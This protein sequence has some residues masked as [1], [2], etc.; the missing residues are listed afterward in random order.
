MTFRAP[1]CSYRAILMASAFAALPL[2]AAMADEAD[3]DSRDILVIGS[4]ESGTIAALEQQRAADNSINVVSSDDV[5]RFPDPNIAEALQRVPGI[6]VQRDQGEGRYIN[7]RGGPAD[8]S[9]VSVD[10]VTLTAPDPST[11]AI[12]LDTIPSG[13]DQHTG[14]VEDVAALAGRRFDHRHRQH[15]H[16]LRIRQERHQPER[17]VGHEPQ[18][19]RRQRRARFGVRQQ[20]LCRRP[21]GR[22]VQRQLFAHG[23]RV[24]NIESVWDVLDTPEGGEVLGLVES[25]FKDYDTRRE[26]IAFTGALEFEPSDTAKYYVR[27]SYS[28]FED[29]EYRNQLLVIWEDG[30][31]Q[32]GATDASAT[33]SDIRIAKQFRHRVQRNEIMTLTAGGENDLGGAKLDYNVAWTT[34]DQTYPSRNELLYRSSLRPTASYDFS[35]NPDQPAI[36]LFNSGEH[37]NLAAY[38]FRENTYRANTTE[39]EEFSAAF[40]VSFPVDDDFEVKVGARYR[41]RTVTADEERWRDRRASSA[42]A[43]TMAD[44]LSDRP[45]SNYDYDLGFK[46]DPSLAKG[47]LLDLRD[48]GLTQRRIPQSITADYAADEK[49]LAGYVMTRATFGATDVILGLR[50]EKTRFDGSSPTFNE[51]TEVIGEETM[52]KR[53]TNWFPN[54]TVRHN[55]TDNLV[56]RAAVTRGI[57]RPN[58]LDLVPRTV[59]NTEGATIRVT[60]G[61]PLLEPTISTNFDASL[62]YYIDRSGVVSAGFFYKDIKDFRFEA[63]RTGTYLGLPAEITQPENAPDGY[64]YGIEVNLSQKLRFLPG[65]LSNFG[66]FANY[67]YTSSR[68]NLAAPYA[69]RDRYPLPGQ[70]KHVWNASVYYE[71]SDF[72]ARLAYTKRSAFLSEL[73]ADDGRFDIYWGGRGQLD[74][75][76]SYK[77]NDNVTVFGEAKNLSNS[78]GVRYFGTRERVYEYEKFGYSLFGGVKVN[79]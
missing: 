40:N 18:R 10:G 43:G 8:F 26:R 2:N 55:F 9:S 77:L 57:N 32:P 28:R 47:H 39:N 78:A 31:L 62:D 38:G 53:Y 25:L 67:T 75:T 63:S 69:G 7:I 65:F 16:P 51:T 27:G 20:H 19:F 36:S 11:R 48:A 22:S 76:T 29:D 79:F 23:P 58:F 24:D 14:S 74:F 15:H 72:S 56:G 30:D 60:R 3:D 71:T 21:L 64:L 41:D 42:P 45:S 37:L 4:I 66:V 33:F 73:N 34:S 50:M 5:G 54:L 1:L 13:R 68:I 6:A 70:S 12:D 17:I 46:F 35:A 49:V 59:E 44:Y 61:N 52:R